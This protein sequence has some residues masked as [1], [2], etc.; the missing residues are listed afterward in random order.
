VSDRV[1]IESR[2][3]EWIEATCAADAA[4]SAA[5]LTEDIVWFPPGSR[6][7]R[8]RQAVQEW[9]ESFFD[10][11]E[12]E[13]SVF[14]VHLRLAGEWALEHAVFSSQLTSRVDGRKSTH[15]GFYL[16]SWRREADG[17]W[18][19]DRY[20]DVTDITGGGGGGKAG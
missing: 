1:A 11:F 20:V 10:V 7:I 18:Y 12:Y 16:L 3:K 8:G 17:E 15:G 13:F 4:R 9:M 6:A 5:L 14:D 2:R 19:I